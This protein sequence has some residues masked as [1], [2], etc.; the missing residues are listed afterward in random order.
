MCLR[1]AGRL[2]CVMNDAKRPNEAGVKADNGVLMPVVDSRSALS[3]AVDQRSPFMHYARLDRRQGPNNAVRGKHIIV[4]RKKSSSSIETIDRGCSQADDIHVR[5]DERMQGR[6]KG[7]GNVGA[8]RRHQ[9]SAGAG[10]QVIGHQ[11]FA[12]GNQLRPC[13]SDKSSA[14]EAMVS[15]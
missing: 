5:T 11:D 6:K 9:A 8:S 1:G 14:L 4:G 10:S 12:S 13:W 7:R 2:L 15:L 3:S